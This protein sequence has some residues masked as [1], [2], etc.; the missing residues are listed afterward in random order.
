MCGIFSYK[1]NKY[2]WSDLSADFGLI[3]YRGPDNSHYERIHDNILF[4]F[5]RLAI[6]G[7]GELGNQPMKHPDD[8]SITLICNGEIYNYRELA[9]KYGFDLKTGSD[10]EII[11][12]MYKSI[13]I[14]KTVL[15]LDGV[16]MFVLHDAKINTL[17]ASRDPM[18]VRP[19]FLGTKGSDVFISSEAKPII[20]FCDKVIPF[21]PGTW[22]S[23]D[24]INKYNRY[25]YYQSDTI[26]EFD[27]NILC[28]NIRDLLIKAVRKR[29][30]SER[31][32]GCLL[33]D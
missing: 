28:K 5:H 9:N 21:P 23:S 7:V 12:R 1:G 14:E 15:E 3:N 24:D 30:M 13:G 29:L 6:M 33:S 16:F 17:F 4:G 10:S 19:G 8:N 2:N 32:I 18:G 31:E 26:N 27:E 22:W 25:F 11:L 20:N